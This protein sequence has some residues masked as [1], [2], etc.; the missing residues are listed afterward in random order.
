M[1]NNLLCNR[2][3]AWDIRGHIEALGTVFVECGLATG[4]ESVAAGLTKILRRL[5]NRHGYTIT[6]SGLG[7]IDAESFVAA[8]RKKSLDFRLL[9][10][11]RDDPR[12]LADLI[13]RKL[14]RQRRAVKEQWE[15][16]RR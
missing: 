5:L 2:M 13:I 9:G 12:K 11:L 8:A 15:K 10:D 16:K 3:I 14:H 7:F 6:K 4:Q 1:L